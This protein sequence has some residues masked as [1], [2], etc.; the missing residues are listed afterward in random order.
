MKPQLYLDHS[1]LRIEAHNDVVTAWVIHK[2][3]SQYAISYRHPRTGTPYIQ[4][5]TENQL[6]KAIER[7]KIYDSSLY[8][9]MKETDNV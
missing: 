4:H 8:K 2:N 5:Y 6:T 9:I 1:E 3:K 7:G